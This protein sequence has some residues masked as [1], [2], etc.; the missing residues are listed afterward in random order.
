VRG[1]KGD[2]VRK[3]GLRRGAM[4]GLRCGGVWLGF[5]GWVGF[6]TLVLVCSRERARS[7]S[8]VVW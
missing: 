3:G 4:C 6:G 1:G 7:G 2:V 8:I 5:E